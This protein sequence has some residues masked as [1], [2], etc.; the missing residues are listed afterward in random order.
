M[1]GSPTEFDTS[2]Q[3]SHNFGLSSSTNND[4]A[5]LQTVIA[6][7]HIRKNIIRKLCGCIGHKA[8][9]YIRGPKFLPPSLIRNMN[10]FST[11]NGDEQ[12]ETP[13]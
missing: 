3:R 11:L 5:T 10:K 8:D 13:R 4:A 6:A 1:I 9:A 2:V 12:T 7:L